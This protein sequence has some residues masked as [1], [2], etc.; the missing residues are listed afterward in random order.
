MKDHVDAI[1]DV[2]GV[3]FDPAFGEAW[4]RRQVEDALAMPGTHFLLAGADGQPLADAGNA[5]GF[6]L[7]RCTLDEEELLLLA[8]A[9]PYRGNGIGSALLA[10]FI[11]DARS[12][13]ISRMFLEM[14]DGN[15]A[16]RL[17]RRH[18]FQNV[19]RRM[20]YYRRGTGPS[21]D[22]ITFALHNEQPG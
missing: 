2:M 13:G 18:G 9:P 21:L 19:G 6:T 5:A 8:V 16:E 17:Y 7:S 4:N 1:M 14:R 22:A 15:P 10:R 3:A 12:R 20:N 11:A